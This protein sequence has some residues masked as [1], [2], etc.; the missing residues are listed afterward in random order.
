MYMCACG[1]KGKCTQQPSVRSAAHGLSLGSHL[2]Q[3]LNKMTSGELLHFSVPL[4]L[5]L[6]NEDNNSNTYLKG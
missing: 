1:G 2:V 3:P 5:S 4:Y 6:Y